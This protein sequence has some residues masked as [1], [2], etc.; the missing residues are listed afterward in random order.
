LRAARRRRAFHS[1]CV[2]PASER[3]TWRHRR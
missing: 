1:A 3:R 2:A